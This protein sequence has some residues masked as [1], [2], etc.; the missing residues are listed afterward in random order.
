MPSHFYG[1]VDGGRSK[2]T[3]QGKKNDG[4]TVEAA[5]M[6]GGVKIELRHID[7]VDYASISHIRWDYANAGTDKHIATVRV[8]GSDDEVTS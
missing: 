4:L 3:R 7:G 5:S 1:T 6:Q 2:A 8:D